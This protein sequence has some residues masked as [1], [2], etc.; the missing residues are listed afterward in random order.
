MTSS[1][2]NIF[3]V[4]GR[5]GGNSRWIHRTKASDAELLMFSLICVWINDWVNNREA[6]D[7][8]RY[9]AHY[10][11]IVMLSLR[12]ICRG[13]CHICIRNLSSDQSSNW[14][15]ITYYAHTSPSYKAQRVDFSAYFFK[16]GISSYI[17]CIV[18]EEAY[19]HRPSCQMSLNFDYQGYEWCFKA[20]QKYSYNHTNLIL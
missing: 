15:W 5:L 9:R 19:V 20:R 6:G 14:V 3:R 4:T 2:G 12:G 7:L 16:I 13:M 8:R 10:D 17:L 1:N 18:V 11:V